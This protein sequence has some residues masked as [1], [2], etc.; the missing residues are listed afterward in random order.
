MGKWH[1]LSVV[2]GWS[3]RLDEDTRTARDYTARALDIQPDN[4]FAL[5]MDGLVN[6][7]LLKRHDVAMRRF[8]DAIE[9]DPNNAL[10]WLLKGTLHAFT[11]DGERAVT[12]TNRARSLSPLDP[13]S[14]FFD[15]LSAAAKLTAGDYQ[16]A[17]DLADRSI[18]ANRRHAS[19][20]RARIVALYY[21]GRAEEARENAEAL[22]RADPGFNIRGYLRNHPAAEFKSGHDWAEALR[23]AGIPN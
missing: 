3:S 11:D 4:S 18:R 17:L 1:V 10:A 21:L 12:Y 16:G 23:E 19:T 5:T 13:H 9:L 15:A 6:N 8:D 22:L 20:L 7:N 14:Y 2:Q